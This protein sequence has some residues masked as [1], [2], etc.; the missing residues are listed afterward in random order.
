[1]ELILH[2]IPQSGGVQGLFD[3]VVDFAP[4]E[5][6]KKLDAKGDVL[7]DRHWKGL[8]LLEH[9]ADAGPEQIQIGFMIQN[10][11][12]VEQHFALRS[13]VR[14]KIIYAVEHA[15]ERRFSTA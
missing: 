2:L 8:R 7:T 15:Q 13:L 1:M 3:L 12:A 10:V 11:L 4:L 14:I 9:H 5:P 6:L